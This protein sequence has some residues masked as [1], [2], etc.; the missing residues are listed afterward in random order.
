MTMNTSTAHEK[1][2]AIVL[3]AQPLGATLGLI[4][5]IAVDELP[6]I[7]EASITLIER[8]RPQS[9][10][11][12]GPHAVQLDERQYESGYGPCIHAAATGTTIA[13]DDM[14]GETAYPDF[15]AQAV[16][17]GI[18]HSLAIALPVTLPGRTAALNLYG[19]N[20]PLDQAGRDLA[21]SFAG[22]AAV[23]LT[24]AAVLDG[25]LAEV[26]QMQA[27]M[28]SRAVIEQAK[29]IIMAKRGCTPEEAFD[30]LR[31]VSNDSNLKLRD[32]A[33]DLVRNVKQTG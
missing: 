19:S 17:C 18:K 21:H 15:A 22:Y 3:S 32:I 5:R 20:A 26:Q 30:A 27:A 1:L 12:H 31:Q 13:I 16:A 10:A 11:F 33:V 9:V 2:A 24:N 29:G 25:A 28:A 14:A 7:D 6:G 4:A 23:A 8:D